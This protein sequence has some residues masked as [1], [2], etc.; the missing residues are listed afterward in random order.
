MTGAKL[1]VLGGLTT[2]FLAVVQEPASALGHYTQ[3]GIAGVALG[4]VFYIVSKRDPAIAETHAQA[5]EKAAE[6]NAKAIELSL[7]R[8][9]TAVRDQSDVLKQHN[10]QTHSL[11]VDAL[12]CPSNHQK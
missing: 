8:V 4:I 1:I 12:K 2:A 11:L 9:E 7:E 6:I 10:D 5:I 3:L